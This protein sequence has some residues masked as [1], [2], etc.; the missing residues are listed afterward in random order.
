MIGSGETPEEALGKADGDKE[1]TAGVDRWE[2]DE[3]DDAEEPSSLGGIAVGEVVKAAHE[4]RGRSICRGRLRCV[5][6]LGCKD[7]WMVWEGDHEGRSFHMG[8]LRFK[9]RLMIK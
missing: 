2:L 1:G 9:A 7:E 8:E 3:G 6:D 5:W 4:F